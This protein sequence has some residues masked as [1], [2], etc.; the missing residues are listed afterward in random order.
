MCR[1]LKEICEF[2][3]KYES[4]QDIM[5]CYEEYLDQEIDKG[6]LI[7][8]CQNVLGDAREDFMDSEPKIRDTYIKHAKWL[9]I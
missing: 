4:R 7:E 8:V 1:E 6:T 2:I 3:D 9:G 5:N